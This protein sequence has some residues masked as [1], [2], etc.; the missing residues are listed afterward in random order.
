MQTFAW[1]PNS[2]RIAYQAD[3][4]TNNV[5][6][7]FTSL[8][9]GTG[10]VRVSGALVAGGGVEFN[11]LWAPDSSRI[12]YAADQTTNDVRELFTVVPDGSAAPVQVSGALVGGGDVGGATF[13]AGDF[14]WSPDSSRLTYV[15]DAVIDGRE[16]VYV[17]LAAS[18]SPIRVST[19]VVAG[20]VV[21]NRLSWSFD[22]L[23]LTFSAQHLTL[24]PDLFVSPLA[25]PAVVLTPGAAGILFFAD[26]GSNGRS[27]F[28][29]GGDRVV[30]MFSPTA[31]GNGDEVRAYLSTTLVETVVIVPTT[32]SSL[33]EVAVR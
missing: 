19:S 18:A 1:A 29:F 27:F 22:S 28:S 16:E 15:A 33:D 31:L 17:T 4:T 2:S 8:P 14:A 7:L 10:N 12:A 26:F 6:E 9:N 3:Q 24:S 23:R 5:F 21:L 20:G 30:A 13:L 32:P 11:F 25:G